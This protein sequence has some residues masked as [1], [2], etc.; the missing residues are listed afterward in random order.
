MAKTQI[1]SQRELERLHE[2]INALE[3]ALSE[4]LQLRTAFEQIQYEVNE[5]LGWTP[6]PDDLAS[7]V[8]DLLVRLNSIQGA[9]LDYADLNTM[10]MEVHEAV[11]SLLYD[12]YQ[13]GV[14]P[15]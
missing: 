7:L 13:E 5:K 14:V 12:L 4:A 11:E 3:E 8:H 2:R 15:R 1:V 10:T 6:V 9:L